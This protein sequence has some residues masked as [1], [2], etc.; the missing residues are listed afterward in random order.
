MPPSW[1]CTVL[2]LSST[3]SLRCRHDCSG[4][5]RGQRPHSQQ[6]AHHGQRDQCVP[7]Q[8]AQLAACLRLGLAERQ[9]R[10]KG[11]I[12]GIHASASVFLADGKDT[13]R[14]AGAELR[15]RAST[16]ALAPNISSA[17]SLSNGQLV[18]SRHQHRVVAHHDHGDAA[19]L[20]IRE[21]C[22]EC[23]LAGDVEV[24]VRLIEH[25]D[26]RIAIQRARERDALALASRQ[27]RAAVAD[28][29]VVAVG[30]LAGS[31]RARG[32]AARRARCARRRRCPQDCA[33][34]RD[35]LAHGA[36]EELDVLRQVA[37]VLAERVA[38][39]AR[40][41]RA[42]QADGARLRPPQAE[43]QAQQRRLARRRS[44]RSRPRLSPAASAKL[45]FLM[46][47]GREGANA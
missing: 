28:L 1:C 12:R 37:D 36:G 4:E 29:R 26:S 44:R 5:R 14:F 3:L 2:R 11:R 47:A 18:E 41:V 33:E 30:E 9:Q 23:G 15:R 21:R 31:F 45:T 34:P 20:E 8:L 13:T 39:P 7:G 24:R 38:V 19:R 25:D 16:A 27:H 35:V 40:D 42:V 43:Q 32:R 6:A 17:P 10:G 22:E 46:S